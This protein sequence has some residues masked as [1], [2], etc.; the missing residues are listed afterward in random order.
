[1][2]VD[3]L[4]GDIRYHPHSDATSIKEHENLEDALR[5]P[6]ETDS[7]VKKTLDETDDIW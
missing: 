4:T 1:M 3:R 7:Y 6:E 2:E 5:H